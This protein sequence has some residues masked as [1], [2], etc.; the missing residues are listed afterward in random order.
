MLTH[1][2][3]EAHALHPVVLGDDGSVPLSE[4]ALRRAAFGDAPAITDRALA[5]ATTPRS[6]WLAAVLL[7][8]RGRYAAAAALVRPL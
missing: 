3:S 8:A 1:R 5:A 7:G 2:A 6:Q 4:P